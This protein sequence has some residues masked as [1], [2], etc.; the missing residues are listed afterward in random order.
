MKQP[1]FVCEKESVTTVK[2]HGMK[3]DL[4]FSHYYKLKE[5]ILNYYMR[6]SERIKK[7]K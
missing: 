7:G 1:C 5:E 4:C 3:Y 2:L 6:E